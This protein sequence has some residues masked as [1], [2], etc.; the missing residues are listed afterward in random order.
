MIS[1]AAVKG[2]NEWRGREF[3]RDDCDCFCSSLAH[4]DNNNNAKAKVR[5]NAERCFNKRKN[6]IAVQF[7]C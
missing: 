7:I 1:L 3:R 6:D 2:Q 4:Y 5:M